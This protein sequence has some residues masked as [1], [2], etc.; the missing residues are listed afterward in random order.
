MQSKFLADVAL[1]KQRERERA[2]NEKAEK[3]RSE[4]ARKRKEAAERAAAA[5]S[6]FV[7]QWLRSL[8]NKARLVIGQDVSQSE[9]TIRVPGRNDPDPDPDPNPDNDGDDGDTFCSL[10]AKTTQSSSCTRLPRPLRRCVKTEA[11]DLSKMADKF[12]TNVATICLR[13]IQRPR[14]STR[15][16]TTRMIGGRKSWLQTTM[17]LGALHTTGR[18]E[19]LFARLARKTCMRR[20]LTENAAVCGRTRLVFQTLP[21]EDPAPGE[22]FFPYNMPKIQFPGFFEDSDD[23]TMQT[24]EKKLPTQPFDKDDFAGPFV[25]GDSEFLEP[26]QFAQWVPVN[27]RVDTPELNETSATKAVA[28]SVVLESLIEYYKYNKMVQEAAAAKIAQL[29][30][31]TTVFKSQNSAS[32]APERPSLANENTVFVTRPVMN[33]G[34]GSVLYPCDAGLVSYSYDDNVSPEVETSDDQP[35][36]AR[37][38]IVDGTGQRALL[39]RKQLTPHLRSVLSKDSNDTPV[40][41]EAKLKENG[42]APVYLAAMPSAAA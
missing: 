28:E 26:E 20:V 34:D 39:S 32:L 27:T 25:P 12:P 1:E 21:T 33:C 42:H 7:D 18:L 36:A 29:P 3:E 5:A 13:F 16:S 10:P 30:A 4:K 6:V 11:L 38:M 40:M 24:L 19:T 8:L 17:G 15:L 31:F 23:N 37:G 9:S 14:G 22:Q 41:T 2:D 35:Y